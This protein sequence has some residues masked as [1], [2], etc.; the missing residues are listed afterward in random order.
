MAGIDKEKFKLKALERIRS[1]KQFW[2]TWRRTARD[3]YAFVAGKQWLTEDEQRMQ[4]ERRPV[5]TFNYSEKMVD[6]VVGAE[7][8][9]RSETS[10]RARTMQMAGAVELLDNA[11]KWVRDQ[12]D[13]EDQE[14]DAFR[15]MLICGLGWTE[16]RLD[17][18]E[19][20]DGKL[21]ITRRDPT[22]MYPDP[23]AAACGLTDR[24]FNFRE[25]YVPIAEA[26]AE[27]PGKFI[28]NS[29][30]ELDRGTGIVR[31]GDPY[32]NGTADDNEKEFERRKDTVPIICYECVERQPLYRAAFGGQVHQ[33]EPAEFD[34][35][36]DLLEE[37]QIPYVKQ[38]KR[39][40]YRAYFNADTLLEV[41]LSPCQSGFLYN[42]ITGKRDRNDHTWYGLTRVMKDPQ[43]WANKWLSQILHI[44]NSNAKGGIMAEVNA[45]VDPIKAQEDWSKPDSITLMKEGAISGKRVMEKSMANYPSGL[46]KLMQFA[47]GSLPMVTGINLEALGLANREQAGVLESQRKQAAYG[48]LSPLFSALRQYRKQQGRVLGHMINEYIADNRLIRIGGPESQQFLPLVKAKGV[49]EFDV[50]VDQSPNAP[51]VKE[52]TWEALVQLVPAMLKAGVPIPPDVLDYAPIPTALSAKW[53]AFVQQQ[54]Q[55]AGVSP[56]QVQQ[57]QEQLQQL[58]EEN[59]QLKMDHTAEMQELQMKMAAKQAELALKQKEMEI[60]LQIAQVEA[61]AKLRLQEAQ[62]QQKLAQ[63]Q[64]QHDQQM[65][66]DRQM[67]EQQIEAQRNAAEQDAGFQQQKIDNQHE[68]AMTKARQRPTP[69]RK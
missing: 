4:E 34:E 61:D 33:M 47:L 45:F 32:D 64:E 41:Q 66:L 46:D 43:R 15:D 62:G 50:I 1:A 35:V 14:T 51:D 39:V 54:Q 59:S 8:S 42:P 30:E 60:K 65:E 56:E 22:E 36:R 57:M 24:T 6:A 31:P 7:V 27:W 23:A 13:A 67:G 18:D 9:N 40:Y 19:D 37:A 69:R 26:Q 68:A 55:Q 52:A 58:A 44:V 12:C 38:F 29:A 49:M 17:Y 10:F 16:T 11:A 21:L 28:A 5:I 20:H 3:D 48:L 2:G 63:D 53:K 25:Y